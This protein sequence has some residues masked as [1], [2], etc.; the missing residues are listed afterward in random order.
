M[1]SYQKSGIF[2]CLAAFAISCNSDSSKN[3]ENI[4]V[5]ESKAIITQSPANTQNSRQ[6]TQDSTELQ[7]EDVS[8]DVKIPGVSEVEKRVLPPIVLEYKTDIPVGI[9]PRCIAIGFKGD[10]TQDDDREFYSPAQLRICPVDDYPKVLAVWENDATK[11]IQDEVRKLSE[12]LRTKPKRIGTNFPDILNSDAG[13]EF[14]VNLNYISFKNG[15]GFF[16]MT[17]YA[18]EATV[19]S[20][21]NIEYI[22]QGLT[23]DKKYYIWGRFPVNSTHLPNDDNPSNVPGWN[24]I[25]KGRDA[26]DKYFLSVKKKLEDRASFTPP[27]EQ[28]EET[29]KSLEIK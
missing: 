21:K 6:T 18:M 29:V 16:V 2:L 27:L 3:I 20:N 22:F 23:N 9:H 10:Y 13:A 7:P 15:K 28:I 14:T 4:T 24:E 17:Q 26:Y 8:I 1:K 19:V 11:F 25:L 12:V 5:N